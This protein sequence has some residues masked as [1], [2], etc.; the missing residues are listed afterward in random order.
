ME[1][2]SVNTNYRQRHR[3]VYI[4]IEY[5]YNMVYLKT[6]TCSHADFVLTHRQQFDSSYSH[7]VLWVQGNRQVPVVL[8]VPVMVIKMNAVNRNVQVKF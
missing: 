2:M 5:T 6:A 4:Y 3:A 8:E 1:D 7:L